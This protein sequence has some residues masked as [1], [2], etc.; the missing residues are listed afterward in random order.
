MF[1]EYHRVRRMRCNSSIIFS[2]WEQWLITLKANYLVATRLLFWMNH[3]VEIVWE[4]RM[5]SMHEYTRWA[6][7]KTETSL[8]RIRREQIACEL[9]IAE[10]PRWHFIHKN[11]WHTEHGARNKEIVS[12]DGIATGEI[13]RISMKFEIHYSYYYFHFCPCLMC[14]RETSI[15]SHQIIVCIRF[16]WVIRN[17]SSGKRF[18]AWICWQK[19]YIC[20]WI[21]YQSEPM[22][23]HYSFIQHIWRNYLAILS[24]W[25]IKLAFVNLLFCG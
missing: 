6:T 2:F 20:G 8:T 19:K 12:H 5:V 16:S 24:N 15:S 17:Q 23:R 9:R 13:E 25:T 10:A 11:Y 7:D 14:T 22:T 3:F 4:K 21:L 18:V 1:F